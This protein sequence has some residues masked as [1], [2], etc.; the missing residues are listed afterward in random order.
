MSKTAAANGDIRV[1]PLADALGE[2]YLAYAM[3][4]IVSRSL[5]DVRDGLKPVHRRLLFAMRQLKLDPDGGFKK[6][7]RVVGDVIGK[8]HPHGDIAVYDTLVRLA[9]DFAVRYPLVE[10]QGNFGNIDGDNAAAMRYTEAKLTAVAAALMD[11]LDEDAVDFRPTYDGTEEE[12]VVMPAAF[13][14]LLANGAAGIAVGMATS[15]PPHNV[16]E[17]CDALDLLIKQPDC[18][19]DDLIVRMPGPDFPTGGVLV[20]SHA[21]IAE[22]YRTGKGSFR[23]RARWT[24]EKL[25]HGLYQIV[26]TE[27]PYQVQ[28]ARLIERIAEL[29][30]EKKL[31]LL[32]D[33]RDESA[34]DVRLVL[35][36]RNRTVEAA[37]V[38]EQLF[39]QT[40]LESRVPLN[41]N[42]LD[43]NSVPRVMTLKE[44]LRAFLDHRMVVLERRSRFRLDKI[45]RRLEILEGFLKVYADLDTVIRI[46][47]YEDNPKAGLIARF[48]LT[49]VQAEAI[50]NMRL[51]SLNKL[52]EVEIRTEHDA[53][54]AEKAGLVA[55]LGDEGQ[56]W[57]VISGQIAETRKAFGGA[58]KL[59]RRRTELGEVPAAA[60]VPIEAFVEREPIT[61]VLSDKG[62]VRAL[63][64]HADTSPE[65]LK[66]KEGDELR[67]AVKTWTTD[68]ILILSTDGR[69]FTLGGDR[70]PSGR[71]HGEPLRLMIDLA[72]EADVAAVL[73]HQPGRRLLLATDAGR[74]FIVQESEVLA[75]TRAGKMVLN[76][77]EGEKAHFCLPVEGDAVAIIGQNRKMLVFMLDEI[78]ELSRGRGVILQKYRDC[79]TADIKM[80]TLAEGL[81]WALGERTRTETALTPW[82]GKR[83]SVGR[84]PPS[85]FPRA[86]RFS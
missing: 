26:I 33:I 72:P 8:Y 37:L 86:N 76:V 80:F 16:G 62:W 48:E 27:I 42:V 46:I 35:E 54:S 58:T 2:R 25:S 52:Q 81:S 21:A 43:A 75:Q 63:K 55:L 56:R 12:P 39:R 30:G 36:P 79:G 73:V 20:E 10:G 1:T 24:V 45:D 11:G 85:G 17:I 66:F 82:L 60:V 64:G 29:L 34:E 68:K 71:G 74:G 32:A 65:A 22:A 78:P 70:L 7:A 77:G 28:K 13:P 51:R 5:P 40:D 53:L 41:M 31:P 83:A 4:T 61:M 9:Q 49:E 15:I 38:M 23:L 3:S 18:A 67:L 50:L 59:G 44:V 57:G 47:R 6:C 19:I 14:N 84:L 69:I